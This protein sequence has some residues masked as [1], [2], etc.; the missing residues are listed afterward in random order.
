M[1]RPAPAANRALDILN[2]L[3]AHPTESFTL[4]ELAR[5]LDLNSA[6][7]HAVLAVLTD[8]GYLVRHAGHK[9][10]ALGPAV[11]ALGNAALER[12]RVIEVARHEMRRLSDD[13]DVQI[14]A[15]AATPTEIVFL[16]RVGRYTATDPSPRVAERVPLVPPL[17]TVFLAW[18]PA[19]AVGAWLDRSDPA[20]GDD[21]RELHRLSLDWVR[22]HGY[23]VGLEN[24]A[25]A[26]FGRTL[27]ELTDEPASSDL[28]DRLEKLV[29]RLAREP[30]RP[31]E[32]ASEPFRV[33]LVAAPVFGP[34]GDVVLALSA[35]GFPEP[36]DSEALDEIGQRVRRATAAIT[37]ETH[38][39]PPQA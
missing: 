14:V 9:T 8:A 20:L 5:R 17:G 34:T 19:A 25:R 2:F 1:A 6:S 22:E 7:A 29:D 15:T 33:S 31:T 39:R 28:R 26:E 23:A 4:S 38:G 11:V 35:I 10:Y 36:L 21:E 27:V 13:L 12:H 37:A 30:Y 16:E 18:A 3:A 32:V 24:E